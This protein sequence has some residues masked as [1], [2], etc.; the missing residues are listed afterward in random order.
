MVRIGLAA[1]TILVLATACGDGAAGKE[2]WIK[3][4][5]K[6]GDDR[7][8]CT[9]VADELQK[10]LDPEAFKEMTLT[11]QGKPEQA[12]KIHDRMPVDRQMAK[13]PVALKAAG[14]CAA[15]VLR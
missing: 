8:T 5:A 3:Q 11:A 15:A 6:G 4:C 2:A 13:L 7:A 9:C 12:K 1:A 14:K 10:N